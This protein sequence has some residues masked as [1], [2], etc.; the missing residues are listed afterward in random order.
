MDRMADMLYGL[1]RMVEPLPVFS[2]LVTFQELLLAAYD[3]L[4]ERLE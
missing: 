1:D 4:L 2:D 3:E